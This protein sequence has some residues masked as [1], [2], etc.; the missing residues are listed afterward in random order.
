[1]DTQS[2]RFIEKTTEI[3][4]A[5][6]KDRLEFFEYGEVVQVKSGF[7]EVVKIDVRGQRLT[8]KPIPEPIEG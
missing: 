1:M 3:L 7:F 2:G 4:E 8:L 5:E 6:A